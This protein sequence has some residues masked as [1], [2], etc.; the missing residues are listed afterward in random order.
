MK[1]R[2]LNRLIPELDGRK[3]A[4]LERALHAAAEEV[5]LEYGERAA[6]RFEQHANEHGTARGIEGLTA[7]PG[8]QANSCMLAVYPT[9]EQAAAMHQPNGEDPAVIHCTLAYLGELDPVA[10]GEAVAVAQKAAA[11]FPH[12]QLAGGVGGIA[13]FGDNGN[14]HPS[15]L[16]PDVPGLAELRHHVTTALCD[17]GVHYVGCVC[18]DGPAAAH[19][20][21][22][23]TPHLTLSYSQDG[24]KP[25]PSYLIGR[26]LNFDALIFAQAD[27]R[28]DFPLD[29]FLSE[30]AAA[31][32][33]PIED[34]GRPT[35][36]LEIVAD[37]KPPVDPPPWSQPHPDE[38]LDA[39]ALVRSFREKADEIRTK[40]IGQTMAK[41][42]GAI[43]LGFDQTNP[44]IAAVVERIGQHVTYI[45]DTT[46][47]NVMRIV[48]HSYDAG[49]SIPN[50]ASAI[51][52]GMAA[53]AG[54]RATLIARTEMTAL[55]NGGSLAAAKIVDAALTSGGGGG[56]GGDGGDGEAFGGYRKRW[57][58]APGAPFPRHEEYEGLD[59]QTVELDAV[60]DVGGSLLQYPGDPDGPPDEVCNCRCTLVYVD[61]A[62]E[63]TESDEGATAAALPF[64]DETTEEGAT[65]AVRV[66]VIDDEAA[67]TAGTILP[68]SDRDTAWDVQAARESLDESQYEAAA[69]WRDSTG[70]PKLW[71]A[72]ADGGDL[73]AIWRGVV[74]CAG[75][76]Q[77]ARGG[78]QVPEADVA[79]VKAKIEAYYAKAADQYADPTIQVPWAADTDGLD[80][81]RP[82]TAA[83]RLAYAELGDSD[84]DAFAGRLAVWLERFGID[85]T[86]ETLVAGAEAV[87]VGP[88]IHPTAFVRIRPNEQQFAQS[89]RD[90]V[91]EGVREGFATLELLPPPPSIDGEAVLPETT[92]RANAAQVPW[93][94]V[95]LPEG[96]L[97]DDGRLFAPHSVTWR[98]LPLTLMAMTETSEGGHIG[99]F[100]AGRIERIW[101]DEQA[102]P[103]LIMAEGVFDDGDD[104]QEVARLVGDE[105][106][107]GN[108]VDT[109]I[110]VAE[111]GPRDLYVDENGIWRDDAPSEAVPDDDPLGLL[112]SEDTIMVARDAVIGMST[113]CPFPAFEDA[114]IVLA[115]ACEQHPAFAIVEG[116]TPLHWRV[117]VAGALQVQDP[118]E[119]IT[120]S[121]AGLVP[122]SPPAEW[123]D[124]P[125]LDEL[126]ALTVTEDGRIFGHAWAWD[127]CHT[128]IPGV[129]TTPPSSPT[130]YGFFHLKEVVCEDGQT[131]HVGTI[132]LGT[133]HASKTDKATEAAEH[134][135][136]TGA[137]VADVRVYEDEFGGAIAGAL[138][139]ETPAARVREFRGSVLS[140]DWRKIDGAL[141]LIALL[142]VN[143]PGFPVPRMQAIAASADGETMET[144]ALVAAGHVIRP[145]FTTADHARLRALAAR[146]AGG[147][148]ALAAL[149]AGTEPEE[150]EVV[151]PEDKLASY[152]ERVREA[153]LA[154]GEDPDGARI[155]STYELTQGN[156]AER[157]F[158]ELAI[159]AGYTEMTGGEWPSE[160]S[161][162]DHGKVAFRDGPHA[163]FVLDDGQIVYARIHSGWAR[164]AV[165]S[166]SRQAGTDT[167]LAF[168]VA[169]PPLYR[170][171][172]DEHVVPVT[173]WTNGKWGPTSRLRMIES[174]N[175]ADIEPNYGGD[176][177]AELGRLMGPDFRPG[178]NGQLLLWQGSPGTGKTWALRALA[179]EWSDWAEFSYITDPDAFFVSD[180]S[181]MIDVLLQ[182]SYEQLTPDGD[183]VTDT[184][185]GGKWRVLIL[186]DTGELLAANAKDAYG[187]GLSRL[188]NVVDGMVGQGLRV[189]AVLTTNDELDDLH[190]AAVR[191]GRC[192][193]QITFGTLSAEEAREWLAAK[194]AG[195]N[196][197]FDDVTEPQSLAELYARAGGDHDAFAETANCADCGHLA[198]VH[199]G[200]DGACGHDGCDCGGFAEEGD[201]GS[202][203]ATEP[204]DRSE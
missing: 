163:V 51:R 97:T 69:F 89:I 180:P 190:P 40:V 104:G 28:R 120:A 29:P 173:F 23:W 145:D 201:G 165:A 27:Q 148:D 25:P 52:E 116:K 123:F 153:L 21:H 81:V 73:T 132:T 128:G 143:V 57:L 42:L 107:R 2:T 100:L 118:D 147:L 127:T 92:E 68:L 19:T 31:M 56:D 109:A 26:P 96:K 12:G 110:R 185:A 106:L 188:L 6:E 105:T 85:P 17:A 158:F 187:Q 53:A 65:V 24:P 204:A 162:R 142:A 182:D 155:S 181:Y 4:P 137:A 75:V 122:V 136:H 9:D 183:V 151:E 39:A 90:A 115:S 121:A 164:F 126:T 159:G 172:R 178:E 135:D 129:C 102:L 13:A 168:N 131:V 119:A 170:E 169:Y 34:A 15:I 200:P 45:A 70:D 161:L 166:P 91:R 167:M 93:R 14:G 199:E 175:W 134:Y 72:S 55:V 66:S 79:A 38:L 194:V 189:L 84:G 184:K 198:D 152:R 16:L 35:V 196:D 22:G 95:F 139:P 20:A 114:S 44:F 192:A 150:V 99:A 83:A 48:R 186:E 7:A 112:M 71:H 174:A 74:S 76:I 87:N 63:E 62:G 1:A 61:G 141:E 193:S 86:E 140:G 32:A 197:R 177:R 133:G 146:A 3:L 111:F 179:S 8:V 88:L 144:L 125:D 78:F 94:A 47:L 176:V 138:R 36:R 10:A 64:S 149:A 101:R 195:G 202:D 46:R 30:L 80:G 54:T 18:G 171:Q 67:L 59:G 157:K 37:G 117:L 58:T 60:F 33:S 203:D 43:G 156:L 124:A 154:S 130:D 50:T 49:L 160:A 77:G 191:P 82:F 113:V 108:S 103:Y 11:T 98:E 41:A 5:L